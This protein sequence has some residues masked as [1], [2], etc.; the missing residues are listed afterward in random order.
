MVGLC[1]HTKCGPG[2]NE[3]QADS[4][5][6]LVRVTYPG[7]VVKVSIWDCH[8]GQ[9]VSESGDFDDAGSS[10]RTDVGRP[11]GE[12]GVFVFGTPESGLLSY[13]YKSVNLGD[14]APGRS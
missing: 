10:W 8:P 6:S 9:I 5:I 13:S 1:S 7:A 14:A 3:S 11:S 2:F 4:T 12:T